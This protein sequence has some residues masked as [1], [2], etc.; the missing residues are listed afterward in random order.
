MKTKANL[1]IIAMGEPLVEFVC[2]DP[3]GEAKIYR[4]G[5]GGDTSNAA[6]A[7]ARQGAKVGYITA[8]GKDEFG[9]ALIELWHKENI[10]TATIVRSETSAS[11]VYFVR[12]HASGR[13]FS[14]LRANS[15]ASQFSSKDLNPDYIASA[16]ILHI[17]AI[18][19]AISHSMRDAASAAINLARKSKVLV[20]YD[21]NLRLKLW[22][23]E[24]AKSAIFKA[25]A[26]TDIV[27]PSDDE[28]ELLTGLKSPDDIIKYFL[29][30]GV[31]IVV[32]KRGASGAIV[33]TRDRTETISPTTVKAIDSTGAGDAFA[34]SFLAYFCETGDPFIAGHRA[35]QVAAGTVAG[36]G[37]IEPI[38]H[39][40]QVNF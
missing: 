12:P 16:R 28:A 25:M 29:D 1:D 31:K 37:A 5:F 8:L 19:Q 40:A 18:T 34:G 30:L 6:I 27:F 35:A 3:D 24:E 23:L 4:K 14:Y 2:T 21:T 9:D 32:L 15:A 36:Y 17:S 13:Q 7:A 38:P 22:P 10:D 33:A 26:S 11:G 39:R 20:S